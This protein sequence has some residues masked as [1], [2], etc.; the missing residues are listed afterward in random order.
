MARGQSKWSTSRWDQQ[1]LALHGIVDLIIKLS[2]ISIE[3]IDILRNI[4]V[5]RQNYCTQNTQQNL[6]CS[7]IYFD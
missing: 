2:C 7:L 3:S 5:T 1:I 4:D 6:I